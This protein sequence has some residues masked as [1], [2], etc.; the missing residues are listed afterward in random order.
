MAGAIA[1]SI[2]FRSEC[3]PEVVCIE[4]ASRRCHS[5]RLVLSSLCVSVPTSRPCVLVPCLCSVLFCTLAGDVVTN[6]NRG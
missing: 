2:V 5:S 4:A 6:G 3:C 1:P